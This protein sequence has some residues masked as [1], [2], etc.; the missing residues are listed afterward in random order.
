MRLLKVQDCSADDKSRSRCKGEALRETTL[1]PGI[2][3]TT[4]TGNLQRSRMYSKRVR[5][6]LFKDT[7]E[8][9]R[10]MIMCIE[11]INHPGQRNEMYMDKFKL[12]SP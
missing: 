3:L 8:L 2:K 1:S 4:L 11:Q 6:R 7:E 5:V 9:L 10:S 12:S